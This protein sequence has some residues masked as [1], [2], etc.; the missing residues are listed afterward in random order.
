MAFLSESEV[1]QA[2]L[3]QLSALGYAIESEENIGPDGRRP[4]RDSHD[5]V[6]LKKR[7]ADS[8]ARL[9]PALPLEARGRWSRP[10]A[11]RR[12]G[13][14]FEMTRRTTACAASNRKPAGTSGPE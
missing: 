9:N 4:E 12:K 14:V 1:E 13:M 6:V 2:L 3:D 8:V 10:C 7:F 11:H 5:E